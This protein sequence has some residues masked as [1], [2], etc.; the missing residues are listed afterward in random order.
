V[1]RPEDG[2]N[3][4]NA[5]IDEF[6]GK[7]AQVA[8]DALVFAQAMKA[9]AGAK[10]TPELDAFISKMSTAV[11]KNAGGNV[12]L[13]G[14]TA[15]NAI[16]S[17]MGDLN[18]L[19][20]DR[21]SLVEHENQLVQAGLETYTDAQKK[22]QGFYSQTNGLIQQQ[23]DQVLKL[24]ETFKNGTPQQ[25]L[26]YQALVANLQNVQQEAQGTNA[27]FVNLKGR[28]TEILSSNIVTFIDSVAQAFAN[29][30]TGQ[31]D[32]LD[33][34]AAVGR[35][36]LQ[37]IANILQTVATLIIEALILDAV[38]KATGGILKPLLQI[39]AQAAT[40]RHEGGIADGSGRT[41]NVS[42][43]VFANAPRY[44]TGGIAGLAP[45][46]QAT[47]LKKGEEV[48]TEADPRHRFNG[49]MSPGG[50]SAPVGIRQILAVGDDEIAGAMAGTSGE[51][52]VLTHI[53]RNRAT[54]KQMLDAGA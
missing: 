17:A 10:P 52:T 9:A 40:F 6:A 47:I 36:F 1:I 49:G 26:F 31:G 3:Q 22:I 50:G 14:D 2:L 28:I 45:N 11:Q 37:M 13:K 8:S 7:I 46:E 39:T 44:H 19:V 29:L 23:I 38:D 42:P 15:H 34:L 35:A 53:R 43:L 20:S 33:F 27:S 4:S 30:A 54:I 48:L 12:G 41:R 18:K 32:V 24:A 21:N 5:V 51:K 25:Q 16:D